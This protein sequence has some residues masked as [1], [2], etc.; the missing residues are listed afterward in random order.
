VVGERAFPGVKVEAHGGGEGA[1]AVEDVAG[2]VAGGRE[3]ER[4]SGEHGAGSQEEN[5][6]NEIRITKGNE[7]KEEIYRG[8]RGEAKKEEEEKEV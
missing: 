5:S 8:G 3:G 7:R 1:V 2:E 6:N 4:G